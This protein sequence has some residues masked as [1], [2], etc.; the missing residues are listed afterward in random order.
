MQFTYCNKNHNSSSPKLKV[1]DSA[2]L[3]RDSGKSKHCH[4]GFKRWNSFTLSTLA[5]TNQLHSLIRNPCLNLG[6]PNALFVLCKTN[7]QKKNRM[8]SCGDTCHHKR[9]KSV[10]E[11][12]TLCLSRLP[13]KVSFH[14]RMFCSFFR[15]CHK[16]C[17]EVIL[18]SVL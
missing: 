5:L 16:G 10:D 17:C 7:K 15:D 14:D 6:G 2:G 8:S 12:I 13:P 9:E 4:R 11:Y 1:N 3:R 18:K